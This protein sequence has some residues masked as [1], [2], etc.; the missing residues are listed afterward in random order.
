MILPPALPPHFPPPSPFAPRRSRLTAWRPFL[1]GAGPSQ[2]GRAPSGG[3]AQRFGGVLSP[4][5][6]S[7]WRSW[8]WSAWHSPEPLDHA[9]FDALLRANVKAGVVNY[10]GFQDSAAFRR[11]SKRWASRPSSTAERETL[12][13][14]I[15]AYNALAI[16]GI[17][18]GIVA[19]VATRPRAL[20]QVARNG[21]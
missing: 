17:L 2:A 7:A 8:R 5:S 9:P 18:D 15:N 4:A 16:E 19:V 14:Y 20:F 13:F 11:T 12:A 6:R 1:T 3:S 10:A 21:L